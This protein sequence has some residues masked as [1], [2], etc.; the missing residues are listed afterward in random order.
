MSLSETKRK[1]KEAGELKGI[2]LF[3]SGLENRFLSTRLLISRVLKA[4]VIELKPI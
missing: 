4:T 3:Y 2:I 1:E